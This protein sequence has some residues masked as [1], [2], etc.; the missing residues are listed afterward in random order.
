VLFYAPLVSLFLALTL[1]V[2]FAGVL[3]SWVWSTLAFLDPPPQVL[4]VL[5]LSFAHPHVLG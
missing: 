2:V 5:I 4:P 1:F 3:F